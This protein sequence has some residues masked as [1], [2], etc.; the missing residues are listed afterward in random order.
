[1]RKVI[2]VQAR[3]SSSRLP[4]KVLAEISGKTVIAHIVDRLNA[5]KL[6][7]E[8]CVAIPAEE[9][10]NP[11]ADALEPLDASVVRG[12]ANDVLGRYIQAAYATKADIIVRATGDN[13]LVSHEEI[14]RQLKAL[15]DDPEL[16]YVITKG[17]PLGITTEAFTLKTLEKMDY[18]T[19]HNRDFREHVTLYLRQN[20]RP[21]NILELQAPDGLSHPDY[22]LSL[23]TDEDLE[24]FKTIY[25][26]LYKPGKLIELDEVYALLD[27]TEQLR[28]ISQNPKS[29][30]AFARAVS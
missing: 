12:S 11:L 15:T 22:K 1:M 14:D 17:Y 28:Q 16:D 9:N 26:H 23:D 13:P 27:N 30:P 8:V 7:D 19:Q 5:A 18:L 24:L 29:L 2:I 25:S 3:L 21:F 10:E 20:P 4:E 6:A